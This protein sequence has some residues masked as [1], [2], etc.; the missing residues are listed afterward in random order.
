[1]G[2]GTEATA[3]AAAGTVEEGLVGSSSMLSTS[4]RPELKQEVIWLL[5]G[6]T[7]TSYADI[8]DV[9]S[10]GGGAQGE[11]QKENLAHMI[12]LGPEAAG[13]VLAAMGRLRRCAVYTG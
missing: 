11:T 13:G 3:A 2:V 8:L 1:M 6:H 5:A 7:D 9:V 12:T 4:S 10:G